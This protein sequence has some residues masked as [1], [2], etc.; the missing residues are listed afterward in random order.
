[1]AIAKGTGHRTEGQTTTSISGGA[2]LKNQFIKDDRDFLKS[3]GVSAE[4]AQ[5]EIFHALAQRIAR[6]SAPAQVKVDPDVAKRQLIR[7][8]V[9]KMLDALGRRDP[10]ALEKLINALEDRARQLEIGGA[11]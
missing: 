3:A 11:E 2:K 10:Q 9:E 4:P 1:M 7:L 8:A 5:A 6:H